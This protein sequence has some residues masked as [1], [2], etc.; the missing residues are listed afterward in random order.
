LEWFRCAAFFVVEW[1]FADTVLSPI[2]VVLTPLKIWFGLCFIL[3]T[4][5]PK[6]FSSEEYSAVGGTE[7]D[8]VKVN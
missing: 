3:W 7:K 8:K 5:H 4:F 6:F 1:L 2:A